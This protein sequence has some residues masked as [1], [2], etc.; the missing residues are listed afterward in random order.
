[1]ISVTN[2]ILLGLLVVLILARPAKHITKTVT[3][4]KFSG[5][6]PE[7]YIGAPAWSNTLVCS[8]KSSD[9]LASRMVWPQEKKDNC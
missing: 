4:E 7:I 5:N 6:V 3:L 2:L 9:D 8:C 1:M